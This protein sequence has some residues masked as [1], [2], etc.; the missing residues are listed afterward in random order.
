MNFRDTYPLGVKEIAVD[1]GGEYAFVQSTVWG[2]RVP[3][4]DRSV[5]LQWWSKTEQRVSGSKYCITCATWRSADL[6]NIIDAH[7]GICKACEPD[8]GVML[9]GWKRCNKCEKVRPHKNFKIDRRNKS[10]LDS[11][12]KAC[13]ADEMFEAYWNAKKDQAA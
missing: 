2:D 1:Q 6:F 8:A 4:G 13:A 12:C 3:R 11:R 10:G 9:P 5:D 7:M